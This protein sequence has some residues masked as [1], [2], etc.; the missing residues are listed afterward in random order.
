MKKEKEEKPKELI[1]LLGGMWQYIINSDHGFH[2]SLG[3]IYCLKCESIGGAGGDYEK[4]DGH[5]C[6]G[7]HYSVVK[8]EKQCINCR[9]NHFVE[10]H[11]TDLLNLQGRDFGEIIQGLEKGIKNMDFPDLYNKELEKFAENWQKLSRK[12]KIEQINQLHDIH[13]RIRKKELELEKLESLVKA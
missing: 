9:S 7:N 3:M 8:A 1:Q 5:D 6:L 13:V 2:T 11:Y 10:I 4:F 12:S